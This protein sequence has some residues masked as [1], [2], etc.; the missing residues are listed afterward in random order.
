MGGTSSPPQ[1]A[2]TVRTIL[3]ILH[4]NLFMPQISALNKFIQ[5]LQDFGKVKRVVLIKDEKRRQNDAEHSFELAMLAWYIIES[6]KL[7]LNKNLAIQYALVHDLVEV[8]AGDTYLFT[9]DENH[10]NSQAKRERA[11]A[12]KI[13][14]RFPEFKN[15]HQLI[16]NYEGLKDEEGRFVYALDKVI[17]ILNIYSDNGR[18][19]RWK[20]VTLD[21][22]VE[23]KRDKVVLSPPVAKYFWKLI[24]LIQKDEK[25]LFH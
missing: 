10:K 23:A 7:K 1:A 25:K 16:K 12:L 2:K 11:A 24:K 20:G 3:R 8:Y 15:L 9:K 22:L 13:K 19:W 6:K 17:P 5:F 18:T 14:K 4:H 21:M